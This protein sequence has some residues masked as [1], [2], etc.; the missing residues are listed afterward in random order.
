ML[1]EQLRKKI[2]NSLKRFKSDLRE[3]KRFEVVAPIGSHI[4]ENE[5]QTL[6]NWKIHF[7]LNKKA[8]AYGPGDWATTEIW[9]KSA[10]SAE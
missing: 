4:N 1:W 5:K 3:E 2:R 9:K 8:F 7:L 6:K 10:H